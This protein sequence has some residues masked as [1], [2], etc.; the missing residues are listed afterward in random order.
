MRKRE[1]AGSC[2]ALGIHE[3]RCIA[4][5]HP[6]LQDNPKVWWDTEVIAKIVHEHVVKWDV[7]AVGFPLSRSFPGMVGLT[8]HH[9]DHHFR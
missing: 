2:K 5:D 4:M 9:P 3:R 7:D 1:L 8:Q 6:D